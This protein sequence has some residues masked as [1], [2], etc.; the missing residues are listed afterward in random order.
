MGSKEDSERASGMFLDMIRSGGDI[1]VAFPRYK[2]MIGILTKTAS[3]LEFAITTALV[4]EGAESLLGKEIAVFARAITARV[5]KATNAIRDS[6]GKVLEAPEQTTADAFIPLYQ[7]LKESHEIRQLILCCDKLQ[8]YKAHIADKD[9]LDGTFLDEMPGVSFVPLGPCPSLNVKDKY[10]AAKTDAIKTLVLIF[11][12]R[13]YEVGMALYN[14][15]TAPDINVAE[16]VDVVRSSI[17]NLKKIPELS[18]CAAAFKKIEESMDLLKGNFGQYYMDFVESR[19]PTVILENFVLD[20][21]KTTEANAVL[22]GQFRKIIGF[23][24][25]QRHKIND[26]Q[27][28]FLFDQFNAKYAAL[29]AEATNLAASRESR[30]D[31]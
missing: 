5:D 30:T 20:I 25:K 6:E 21:S 29:D 13:L 14:E 1:K 8:P 22:V 16:F 19:S 26:P 2:I 11:L 3:L 31:E 10:I 28:N 23:Y 7:E 27:L 4:P 15:Y 18:R 17:S 9:H 24:R 12:H